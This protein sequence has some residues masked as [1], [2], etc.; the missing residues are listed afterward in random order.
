MNDVWFCSDHH[1]LHE[2]IIKFTNDEGEIIRK[3]SSL[4]EMHETFIERHNAVVKPSDKVYFLGDVTMRY[5]REFSSLITR[6]NGHRRLL[7]GNHDR[8]KGTR[9]FDYFEKVYTFKFFKRNSSD[10]YPF[11][12]SHVPVHPNSLRHKGIANVHGHV[13][14]NPVLSEDGTPDFRYVNVSMEAINYTPVNLDWIYEQFR[15]RG[16][17]LQPK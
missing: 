12:L 14:A 11:W 13:H 8:V 3:F 17:K 9:L 1:L 5:D 10:E 6:F 4:N 7:I 2:K 15:I 16:L